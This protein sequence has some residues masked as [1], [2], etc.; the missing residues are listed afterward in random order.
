[1]SV[2]ISVFPSSGFLSVPVPLP[3][4][5]FLPS[6]FSPAL[7][8]VRYLLC[9]F[10]PRRHIKVSRP[11][12]GEV[13]AANAAL[14]VSATPPHAARSVTGSGGGAHNNNTATV[15]GTP[16]W[17]PARPSNTAAA[18]AARLTTVGS[19]LP[20]ARG[21]QQHE[22]ALQSAAAYAAEIQRRF[23][24]TTTA[25][26]AAAAAAQQQLQ[27]PAPPPPTNSCRV[28]VGNVNFAL[29]EV[30]VSQLFASFGPV[31]SCQL[32][33]STE[34][35]AGTRLPLTRFPPLKSFGQ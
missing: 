2:R 13:A 24:A 21:A 4:L 33:A 31:K 20:P 30:E 11:K 22:E 35:R 16:S 3:S 32:V 15:A 28:Y 34:P 23:Q 9:S 29:G 12:L 6:S 27:A 19:P 10:A 7:R 26:A 5:L 17:R 8:C 25:A 1:V 14:S 18:A